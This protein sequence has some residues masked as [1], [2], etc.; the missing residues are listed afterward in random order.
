MLRK[1]INPGTDKEYDI[2]KL[3]KDQLKESNGK[4]KIGSDKKK[5]FPTDIGFIV[6]DFLDKNFNEIMDYQLTATIENNPD[7][8]AKGTTQWFTVVKHFYD[9]FYPKVV[10]MKANNKLEKDN[11][12]RILGVDLIQIIMCM[13]I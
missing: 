10:D 5:L 13:L 6:T 2:Y 9:M 7:D 4:T 11:Y 3:V 12:R 1:K 8:I